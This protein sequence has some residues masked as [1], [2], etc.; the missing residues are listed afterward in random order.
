MGS[1]G[2]GTNAS[3]HWK[4]S[5]LDEDP[6]PTSKGRDP[7]PTDRIGRGSDGSKNHPG[8]LKVRLRFKG[9][10]TGINAWIDELQ[11]QLGAYDRGLSTQDFVLTIQVPAILRD[12]E[13]QD[14]PWEVMVDW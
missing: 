12:N 8:R 4:V 14:L 6:K 10:T 2:F 9:A 3:M 13:E 5:N 11:A 1:G 7:I